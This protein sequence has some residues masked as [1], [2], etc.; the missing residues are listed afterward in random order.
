MTERAKTRRICPKGHTYYK[1]SDC[2]TCPACEQERKPEADFL[3]RLSAPARRALE[4]NGVTT[5]EKLAGLSEQEVLQFHGMGPSS[6]PKLREALHAKGFR[7][8]S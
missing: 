2:P 7:F 8:K 4:A 1:S 6:I 3:L 5:L